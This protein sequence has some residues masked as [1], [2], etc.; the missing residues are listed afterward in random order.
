MNKKILVL[1]IFCIGWLKLIGQNEPNIDKLDDA[2]V[3]VQIFDFQGSKIGH[4]SGFIIDSKGTV[5]TNYH[6]V[7]NAFSLKVVTDINNKKEIH[8]VEKIIKGDSICDLATIAIQNDEKRVFPFLK[9]SLKKPAKGEN[10]RAI[11]CPAD[12]LYMN[13]LSVGI[14]S[15]LYFSDSLKKLIQTNAEI[16]HGSSGGVL[17]NNLDEAI[18]V[19]SGGDGSEDGARANINFAVSVQHI[20]K[21]PLINKKS[22]VDPSKV[23]CQLSFF[24]NDPYIGSVYLYIDKIFVGKFEKYFTNSYQPNCGESGTITRFLYSGEH[25]YTVYFKDSN[26]SISYTIILVP[27]ECKV[28]NVLKPFYEKPTRIQNNTTEKR[29]IMKRN[30]DFSSFHF[31]PLIFDNII[32]LGFSVNDFTSKFDENL[33]IPL[34]LFY[35]ARFESERRALRFNYL[36]FRNTF[37][38]SDFLVK[39]SFNSFIFDYKFIFPL[40]N[41]LSYFIAPTIGLLDIVR[42]YYYPNYTSRRAEN[43]ILI[44]PRIG[45]EILTKKSM[46][47]SIDYA[48]SLLTSSSY[49]NPLNQLNLIIGYRFK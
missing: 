47:I 14:V 17:L 15:N 40:K 8:N 33:I 34:S 24:T 45:L 31:K 49:Y 5:V 29:N 19:T 28:I 39:S 35:E 23:P 32:S 20:S 44:G 43:S 21:L 2:V 42:Y 22:I 27:G 48:V 11:G 25:N 16:A 26:K 30:F 4:G 41:K 9:L 38:N 7:K 13:T 1:F 3:I 6:V 18:G 12:E 10:V 37:D 46:N 36:F